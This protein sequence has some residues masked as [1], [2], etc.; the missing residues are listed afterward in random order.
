MKNISNFAVFYLVCR[1][2]GLKKQ[3][4]CPHFVPF[5]KGCKHSPKVCIAGVALCYSGDANREARMAM[6]VSDPAMEIGD[7]DDLFP[8]TVSPDLELKK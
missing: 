3:T 6:G 5:K 1:W 7:S 8:H 2:H 4:E